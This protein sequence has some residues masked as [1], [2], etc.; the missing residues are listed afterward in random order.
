ME[1]TSRQILWN[2][3]VLTGVFV[4]Q[5]VVPIGGVHAQS[6]ASEKLR[7]A[8]RAGAAKSNPDNDDPRKVLP[9]AEWRRVDDAVDRALTWLSRQQ[10]ADG[11]FPTIETGQPAV[12][13]L[14][15][16]VFM[17][18]GHLPSDGGPYGERLE[19]ALQYV[20]D[21]QKQ[22]GLI[23]LKAPDAK[24]I[25]RAVDVEVGVTTAY[26]HAISSLTA[27][28]AFGVGVKSDRLQKS[29][30][31]ALK[32]TLE[33]Q[34]WRKDQDDDKGGWRYVNEFDQWDS[35]LSLTGWELMFLRSARNAGFDVPDKSIDR[36]V[37]YIRR[38]FS[39]KLGTFRYIISPNDI[40]SRGMAGAGI[41]AMAH[42]G[43]HNSEEA[44]KAGDWLLKQT[45][46]P[47]NAL[48]PYGQVGW[49]HDR[50][51]YGVFYAS[52]GTYQLGGRYW[53]EF[54]PRIVPILLKNQ[55]ADGSWDAESHGN[56]RRYG[57]AYTT[58]LVLLS[59]GAPNQ[60][61]P[62]FQR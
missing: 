25:I 48:E 14:C 16:M 42:A 35:D 59:L 32:T 31:R 40:H 8:Q 17:A 61:L 46:E 12:T 58:A 37:A 13:S 21:C 10:N 3:V 9:K 51:H 43:F 27:S 57:N 41:L 52:Q 33:M 6:A 20:L 18:H 53:K 26:N 4:G 39:N 7:D 11:S 54:F 62:I 30:G 34:G 19:H 49:L 1:A 50:Y 44:Q 29:I 55:Q 36:A 2:V 56:D 45:F 60:L 38:T 23:A 22:N 5:S 28:E 24:E 15:V 47:Y